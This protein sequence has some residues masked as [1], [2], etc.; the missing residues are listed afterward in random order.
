MRNHF[1]RAGRVANLPS[2]SGGGS[3]IV[4]TDLRVHY[5]FSNTSCWTGNN[6]SNAAD[7]TVNNL[8]NDYTDALFRSRTGSSNTFQHD[9]SS[10]VIDF[11]SSDGGGCL[12]YDGSRLT[13]DDDRC[14]LFIAGSVTTTDTSNTRYNMPTVTGTNNLFNGIGTGSFTYELWIKL[15]F[16]NNKTWNALSWWGDSTKYGFAT[17]MFGNSAS[18]NAGK[19]LLFTKDNSGT[20]Q[21]KYVDFSGSSNSGFSDWNHLV[22]SKSSASTDNAKIYVNNS[23]DDTF[24]NDQSLSELKYANLP[25]AWGGSSTGNYPPH[26]YG[27]FRFYK[28]K[29]LTSSEVTTNWNAQK[30][31]FGH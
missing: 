30:S 5:D 28:G 12:E 8:A 10:P 3:S 29:A 20:S 25:Y 9:S 18:S 7:Y 1:L 19:I 21:Y 2:D 4:T 6:S 24:A 31:R 14:G 16:N 15:D 11:I 22:Y 13:D 17:Y 26:R 27:I 23:L